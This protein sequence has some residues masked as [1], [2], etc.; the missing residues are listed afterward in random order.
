MKPQN[1]RADGEIAPRDVS[2]GAAD[3]ARQMPV[4]NPAM[5]GALQPYAGGADGEIETAFMNPSRLIR[6]GGIVILIFVV[7]FFGWASLAQLE[8]AVTAPGV[9]VVESHRKTIQHLEGGIVKEVLVAEGDTVSA[10]QPLLRLEET[11]AESN[12]S[13]LQDQANGLMAQAA[14]LIA[15]R[16][17]AARIEFPVE[18]LAQRA[19]PNVAAIL[20]GEENTFLTRRNTLTKQIDILA[21]RN[22]ENKRQIAGLQ[23]Q[24][25]AVEKQGTLI[26]QEA[27]G[28]EDLYKQGLSTLPRVLALRRQ[29]ADLTGQG[30]QITEHMAEIELSSEEN[31]L[32]MTN[33]RNQALTS[34]ANDL[35][36][37]QTKKYDVL[38]RLNAAKDIMTRL[39]LVAPVSGKVVNLAIHTKGAVIKPGDTVM[40]IVPANDALEI[41]AHVRPDNADIILSGMVAHVSFNSYKQRRLPQLIGKVD[42]V[43]ADRLVDQRT[44]QPY[45]NVTVTVDREAL[46]EFS[47][48]RLVPGLPA[49]VAIAT[50][51]RTLMD[52]FLAPVLDVIAK[53]MREQ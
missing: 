36:D 25:A 12:F 10:G 33:L 41:E 21:Q 43:S 22:D 37:V 26:E 3:K 44:G 49:D 20:A 47:A 32:Q 11:Q 2:A 9:I 16:D 48:V 29:G 19:N 4:S 30:G 13:L 38:A 34:V 50:G 51:T 53:G 15:E 24:Q 14:R 5:A 46:K 40:E 35:R 28:V 27:S 31:N 45:F 17:G 1:E 52:Y 8:S 42:T 18:L 7:G 23:S 6:S 39:D